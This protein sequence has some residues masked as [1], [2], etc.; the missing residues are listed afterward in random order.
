MKVTDI[1]IIGGLLFAP[2]T[3]RAQYYGRYG[4]RFNPMATML[5]HPAMFQ[6]QNT[7]SQFSGQTGQNQQPAYTHLTMFTQPVVYSQLTM[8][9]QPTPQMLA[10]MFGNRAMAGQTGVPGQPGASAQRGQM[11]AAY[12]TM[13]RPQGGAISPNRS[14][15][16]PPLNPTGSGTPS[17]MPGA[18]R[19]RY[20]SAPVT[21]P[22]GVTPR[23]HGGRVTPSYS[24]VS[25]YSRTSY[26]TGRRP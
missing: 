24:T 14:I 2:A 11:P 15:Y 9:R 4:Q 21:P 23:Y 6:N 5:P 22:M 19:P 26:P 12:P 25:P 18:I 17:G 13:A 8:Y 20:T 3:M 1:L 16:S 7:R 10:I